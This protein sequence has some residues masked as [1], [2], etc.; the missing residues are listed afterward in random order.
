MNFELT[1]EQQILKTSAREFLKKESPV[2]L[3]KDLH[4]QNIPISTRL[5][6][7]MA[8]LDWMGLIIPEEYG[9]IGGDFMDL[10]VILE[11]MGRC[12]SPGPYF[13]SAVMSTLLILEFGTEAQKKAY[14]PPLANGEAILT[15]ALHES[16]A[17]N[18][19]SKTQATAVATDDAYILNGTKLFVENAVIADTIICAAKTSAN[20]DTVGLFAVDG[21]SDGLSTTPLDTLSYNNQSEAV[22][23]DVTVPKAQWL[24]EKEISVEDLSKVLD[25]CTIAK[26]VEMV[27]NVQAALDKT[28]DYAKQRK[29]FNQPIGSFQAIQHHCTNM[30]IETDCARH[31]TWY[32]AW[33]IQEGQDDSLAV[34]MA[35]RWTNKA[36]R[37]VTFKG[38]LVHGA[39]A[40]CEE[41]DMHL[42]YRTAKAGETTF[43]T[44]DPHLQRIAASL[45]GDM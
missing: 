38:H 9:G 15:T 22:L 21:K 24:G 44:D 25:Q 10:A 32:A 37:N 33:K 1:K 19:L 43:G 35:K 6:Q 5:W 18:D 40:F 8:E 3:R 4:Q 41:H 11:E 13:S 17:V 12:C 42:H 36:S 30:L 20:S 2:S 23:A 27:G 7:K 14:L 16:Q 39:I 29:Q 31:L 28:V 45:F 34:S 26:C